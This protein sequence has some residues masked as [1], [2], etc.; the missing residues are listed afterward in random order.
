MADEQQVP[1]AVEES[2]NRVK[3]RGH[4]SDFASL[5]EHETHPV[6]HM[7]DGPSG[8]VATPNG[9]II[10][11]AIGGATALLV[12]VFQSPWVLGLGLAIF[13]GAA[14]WAGVSNRGPGSMGGVGPST[15]TP[16]DDD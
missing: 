6:D 4:G 11:M 13:L 12:F 3:Q 1:P 2:E 16:P 9:P 7:G 14:I 8:N 5:P 15:I 10:L